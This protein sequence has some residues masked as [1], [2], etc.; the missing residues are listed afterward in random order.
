N[1]PARRVTP[2]MRLTMVLRILL[3][4][5]LPDLQAAGHFMHLQWGGLWGP[6]RWVNFFCWAVKQLLV[7]IPGAAADLQIP[8]PVSR[9]P[10]W[11]LDQNRW[12]NHPWQTDPVAELPEEVDTL[13]IGAGF[14]G[15][16]CAFHWARRNP[17]GR[18]LAVVEMDDPASG[19]SGRNEGLVVMGRYFK[20]VHDTV[21]RQL[22]TSRPD[23]DADQ[24]H[25]LARQFAR[26]YC[27]AAY[28]NADL[29]AETMTAHQF[30][31]DYVRAGWVQARTSS[32][33]ESLESSVRMAE[34]SG[35][36]DWTRI[37]PATALSLSGMRLDQ[38]AGFSR[39]SASWHPAKWVWSLFDV[40]LA[41]DQVQLFT[42]T[43]VESVTGSGPPYRVLTSRGTILADHVLYATESY[44]PALAH[45]FHDLILPMQEQAA[46]GTGGPSMMKP[47]IGISGSWYFAGRYGPR[48]LFGSGG[49]RLPDAQAGRNQPSRFLTRFAAA[50]MKEHFG[51]YQLE[52]ANEWSGTVGYTP[53]EFPIVGSID[54][55]GCFIIAGMCGSGSGVS[56][57]A[58]RCL[59]NRILDRSDEPDDYPAEYFAP[60]RLLDPAGHQWPD[61]EAPPVT[62][63]PG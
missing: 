53:D 26:Q 63:E 7:E 62:G 55:G 6:L 52:L 22:P 14:S 24:R 5:R 3:E 4:L 19:A 27:L 41:S 33:Q 15:A 37:D 38:P 12:A 25:Q 23:L 13:I 8:R 39:Q 35:F 51:P 44:T 9:T 48:V 50:A 43:R 2:W 59:V 36:R 56:F 10:M 11:L 61:L 16:A 60:S 46:S 32:E 40:A 21:L 30:D 1:Q 28:H 18:S 20:M 17:P 49:S 58:A 34:Q 47:H 57:N 42:R 31:C 54:D 45:I 29:I